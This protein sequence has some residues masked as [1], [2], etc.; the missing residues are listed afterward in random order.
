[1]M[2]TESKI[3]LSFQCPRQWETMTPIEG[4]RFCDDCNK[5]VT[6]FS[7]TPIQQLN[8]VIP[9]TKNAEICG[10]FYAYQLNKPFGNWRDKIITFSQKNLSGKIPLGRFTM[11]I[12]ML[13]LVITG[14]ARRV[15]GMVSRSNQHTHSTRTL[16]PQN[17]AK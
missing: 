4:G 12:V 6:D 8:T 1:M 9:D 5:T 2:I 15:K 3:K 17:E 10:H 14:C 13:V 7:K 16:D 11:L